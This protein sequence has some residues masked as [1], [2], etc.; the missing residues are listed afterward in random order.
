MK[1]KKCNKCG[2]PKKINKH[3]WYP[4]KKAKSGNTPFDER[5]EKQRVRRL[6][7]TIPSVYQETGKRS[8]A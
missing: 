8:N 4:S 2:E 1:T 7:E 5:C 3:N 6:L